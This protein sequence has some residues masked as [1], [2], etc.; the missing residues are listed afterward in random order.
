MFVP[1]WYCEPDGLG[2]ATRWAEWERKRH[3]PALARWLAEDPEGT[4]PE[5]TT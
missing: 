1:C 2:T 4:Q 3:D 5:E